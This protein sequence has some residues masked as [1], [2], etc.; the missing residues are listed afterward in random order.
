[1]RFL[2]LSIFVLWSKVRRRE[3]EKS[4]TTTRLKN[5]KTV[6]IF[7]LFALAGCKSDS[8]NLNQNMGGIS[9]GGTFVV[10]LPVATRLFVQEYWHN[11]TPHY[12]VYNHNIDTRELDISQVFA[13]ESN[14][15]SSRM[16]IVKGS[17]LAGP[18]S[19][20]ASS[21]AHFDVSGFVVPS[22]KIGDA[23]LGIYLEP[24]INAGSLYPP[25]LNEKNLFQSGL[26]TTI[27]GMNGLDYMRRISSWIETDSMQVSSQESFDF[28]LTVTGDFYSIEFQKRIFPNYLA[29]PALEVASASGVSLR[30]EDT[31]NQIVIYRDGASVNDLHSISFR[32]RAPSVTAP[33]MAYLDGFRCEKVKDNNCIEGHNLPRGILVVP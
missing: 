14:S 3:R 6:C 13:V 28:T 33:I 21:F 22:W 17:L 15:N 5:I 8:P 19:L 26:Y 29:I 20:A 25:T 32:V 23:L 18:W 10:G 4:M 16:E 31:G 24:Q 27:Y 1:M 30:I 12:L 11:G 9:S 2:I 7:L